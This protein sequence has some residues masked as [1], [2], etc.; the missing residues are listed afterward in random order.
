[1]TPVLLLGIITSPSFIFCFI[2]MG[3]KIRIRKRHFFVVPSN[4]IKTADFGTYNENDM[5]T[6]K[7]HAAY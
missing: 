6:M 3:Y 7:L 1:M 4:A 2:F 5:E